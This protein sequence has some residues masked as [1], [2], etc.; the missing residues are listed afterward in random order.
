MD[1]TYWRE[2]VNMYLLQFQY[3]SYQFSSKLLSTL[4]ALLL[5]ALLIALGFWQ[6][7]RA[8]VKHRIDN[9]VIQAQF[10]SPLNLNRFITEETSFDKQVYR[11]ASITGHY[12]NKI[13]FLL[14][15]RTYQGKAGFHVLTPF[16]L[17]NSSSTTPKAILINRG[18]VGY[19]GTRD[20]IPNISVSDKPTTIIGTIKEV[21]D[22][23]TLGDDSNSSTYPKIIQSISLKKLTRTTGLEFIPIII[24]LNKS[25]KSGFVREWQPYYG[26]AD[27]ST[28]YAVQWFSMAIVLLFLYIKV[29]TKK[30]T[31]E[32]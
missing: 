25:E 13:N 31:P 26:T 11:S 14:D 8:E 18:W 5:V 12:D 21:G 1:Q 9:H 2:L 17:E 28:A 22:S 30:I 27:K 3:Q 23:I 4:I 16:L 10:K 6:L 15:N 32:V 7:Y 29:N 24:Q 20:N 19:Q